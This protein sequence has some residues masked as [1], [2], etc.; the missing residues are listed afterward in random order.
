MCSAP[1]FRFSFDGEIQDQVEESMRSAQRS[2]SYRTA[3]W[4][5]HE[6]SLA[7][8]AFVLVVMQERLL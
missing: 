3:R 1:L 8:S 5:N 4:K 6:V 7:V 2:P